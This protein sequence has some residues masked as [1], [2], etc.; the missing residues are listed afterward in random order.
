LGRLTLLPFPILPPFPKPP[1]S[2]PLS[3]FPLPYPSS[4][5]L[6]LPFLS[7]PFPSL[8]SLPLPLEVGPLCAARG[9]EGALKLPQ[10]V[11]AEP[12]RQTFSSAYRAE[13][14]ASDELP[15]LPCNPCS[16]TVG[17][18]I[19]SHIGNGTSS[20]SKLHEALYSSM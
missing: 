1:P 3:L 14:P 15:Y 11:R 5:S 4:L 6:S 12:G 16:H 20:T 13:N 8:P 9:S 7:L 19:P 2:R 18:I 10:R 17:D